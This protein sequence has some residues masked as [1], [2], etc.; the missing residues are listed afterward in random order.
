MSLFL[1]QVK[2]LRLLISRDKT[3]LIHIQQEHQAAATRKIL[4]K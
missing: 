3:F 2:T 1:P 4:L